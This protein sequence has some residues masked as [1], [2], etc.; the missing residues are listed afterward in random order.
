[1]VSQQ[2][3]QLSWSDTTWAILIELEEESAK[4]LIGLVE[5]AFK[6]PSTKLEDYPLGISMMMFVKHFKFIK[7]A[8]RDNILNP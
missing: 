1:M 7:G 2:T 5:K 8:E 6:V 3:M 4:R